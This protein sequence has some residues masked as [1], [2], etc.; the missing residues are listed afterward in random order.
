MKELLG[1]SEYGLIVDDDDEAF[2][3]GMRKMLVDTDKR[4]QYAAKAEKRGLTMT[5]AARVNQIENYFEKIS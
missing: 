3:Q 1:D 5:T 4:Q 2:Y